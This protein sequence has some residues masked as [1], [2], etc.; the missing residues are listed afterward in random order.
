MSLP[1]VHLNE[2]VMREGMQI[3]S[4]E[5]AP[6]DKVRLLDAL[7]ATG[8]AAI[9]VGS[10]VS[11]SYTPQMKEIAEVVRGFTPRPGVRYTYLAMNGR[12]FERAAEFPVLQRPDYPPLLICHLCDT[13]VRRNANRS[14]A[15]E[16]ATWPLIADRARDAGTPAG[17]IGINAAFGSN[18]EGRFGLDERMAV[19]ERAH[20]V[21]DER[22]IPVTFLMLGD[23]MSW[24]TPAE[25]TATLEAALERWP[26]IRDVYLHLHDARGMALASV[27]AAVTTI[28]NRDLH[29][30]TTAGGI[31]GCPYCGN[32]RAT[33][34][35]A[36]EDVVHM[37]T[38]MGIDTGV[39]LDALLRAVRLLEAIIGRPVP[40]RV[41][42]A[43]PRPATP[44]RFYDPNLPLVETYEEAGHWH[45]G[46]GVF[47]TP[48]R[49]WREPIPEPRTAEE[50]RSALKEES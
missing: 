33:G 18:F 42:H 48:H 36:T 10:F 5:I 12:G 37:L 41:A 13:F 15:D 9:N 34:M 16:I 19:L 26:E 28:G 23:P 11:P 22:G 40:G 47:A 14:Q 32:G 46:D 25:T 24:N 49:P 35:A 27:Y 45:R 29:L 39:D 3:E 8:L 6:A 21:W 50:R 17:G 4:V 44:D 30:D 1:R 20:Q 38:D 43:G 7:S 2:E 31:G